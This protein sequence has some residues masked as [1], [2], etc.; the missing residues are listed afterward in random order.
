MEIAYMQCE[1]KKS[2]TLYLTNSHLFSHF[3]LLYEEIQILYLDFINE[4][5]LP[6]T[7]ITYSKP[8]LNVVFS[9]Q[10]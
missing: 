9:A 2:E 7:M 1:N 5:I 3:L 4:I 6:S 8:A 10:P